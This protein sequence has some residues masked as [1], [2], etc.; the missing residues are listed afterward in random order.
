M[1]QKTKKYSELNRYEKAMTNAT[2]EQR[3]EAMANDLKQMALALGMSIH[4]DATFHDWKAEGDTEENHSTAAV[5]F[6]KGDGCTRR[7]IKEQGDLFGAIE[8]AMSEKNP[9]D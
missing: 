4:V 6:I 5:T 9:S 2:L 3:I 1:E 8:E 7:D